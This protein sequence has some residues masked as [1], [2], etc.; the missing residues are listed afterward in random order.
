MVRVLLFNGSPRKYG[1][2]Y[3]L[4][5]IALEGVHDAGGEGEIIHLVDYNIGPCIGCVSDDQKLC[6]FPCP[7]SDDFN[8]IGEEMLRSDAYVF[9]TPI[10]WYGVS[11][12]LKNLIDRMTSM[13]N[14]IVHT[15]RSLLEGRHAG[16]IA[17][18][19]DSGSIMAIAYMM[20]VLNSM[21]VNI[22]PW[23]LAYH[24]TP[25]DVLEDEQAVRDSYNIGYNLVKAAEKI[26]HKQQWYRA[27]I[28]IEAL[29]T[30]AAIDAEHTR[31][32]QYP[33]RMKL[34]KQ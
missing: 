4:L 5:R 8:R 3:K 7:I 26:T 11:G 20:V 22:P 12:L 14:M 29:K 30:L 34:I 1:A 27:G 32:T 19:S 25:S 28:D 33:E 17:V 24:H 10:Y 2:T 9:G 16:F 21:G 18:G 6:R 15:G 13:E 23:A 31:R